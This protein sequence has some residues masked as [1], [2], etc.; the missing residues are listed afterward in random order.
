M[1]LQSD[2]VTV[3]FRYI[4]SKITDNCILY[5]NNNLMIFSKIKQYFGINKT[6]KIIFF[7]S[8]KVAFPSLK[9]IASQYSNLEVVTVSSESQKKSFNEVEL[10]CRK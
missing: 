5:F 2:P 10:Y 4:Q 7:G 6:D 9:Q 1:S 8:G 3:L